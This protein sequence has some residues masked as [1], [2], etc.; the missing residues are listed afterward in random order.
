MMIKFLLLVALATKA[1]S[2]QSDCRSYISKIESQYKIPKGLLLAIAKTESGCRP[3]A[4]RA[5]GRGHQFSNMISAVKYVN[6]MRGRGFRNISVGC[7]QID[8]SSHIRKFSGTSDILTPSR[9]IDYAGKLLSQAYSQSGSW[10]AS[11]RKY[12]S[13]SFHRGY[14]Y[15]KKV[16]R[17]WSR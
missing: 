10:E 17:N 3:W 11:L 14:K 1:Y 16:M 15:V 12:H 6:N 7:M 9:N 4:V 8:V 13:G 2:V 5:A